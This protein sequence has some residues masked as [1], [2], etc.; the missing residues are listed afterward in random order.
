[1]QA[2]KATKSALASTTSLLEALQF[3]MS[4][5][6]YLKTLLALLETPDD[7][8]KRRAL[9][10]FGAAITKASAAEEIEAAMGFCSKV[11]FLFLICNSRLV[12]GR[13]PCCL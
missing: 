4:L 8:I 1:M 9:R 11:D 2:S 3:A 6:L 13:A 7:V 5:A 10:L 12:G